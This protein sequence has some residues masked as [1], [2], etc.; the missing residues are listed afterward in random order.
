M[1]ETARNLAP[2]HKYF[3][4]EKKRASAKA[5]E[6]VQGMGG[7]FAVLKEQGKALIGRWFKRG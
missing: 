1:W 2:N 5:V 7:Q 4:E 6:Q 3:I